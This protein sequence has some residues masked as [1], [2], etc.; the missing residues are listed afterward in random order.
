MDLI[1]SLASNLRDE[2]TGT[3]A[4]EHQHG[5][6]PLGLLRVIVQAFQEELEAS[7]GPQFTDERP[8][9]GQ[10]VIQVC[11]AYEEGK[12]THMNESCSQTRGCST[13]QKTPPPLK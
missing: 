2:M 12:E 3:V 4:E 10:E 6:Q 13:P 9:F 7:L 1:L 11:Q 5:Q 8:Q